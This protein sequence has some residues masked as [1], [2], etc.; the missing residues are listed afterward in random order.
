MSFDF[1]EAARASTDSNDIFT[2]L[3]ITNRDAVRASLIAVA[4]NTQCRDNGTDSGRE[5]GY[6]REDEENA[7]RVLRELI[8]VN[9]T[10]PSASRGL[11][12][13]VFGSNPNQNRVR[14]FQGL[15]TQVAMARG[16]NRGH[17]E[18][19]GP[20]VFWGN[21]DGPGASYFGNGEVVAATPVPPVNRA[22]PVFSTSAPVMTPQPLGQSGREGGLFQT[23]RG[24]VVSEGI[25][26]VAPV[27]AQTFR[28]A[29]ETLKGNGSITEAQFNQL[30]TLEGPIRDARTPSARFTLGASLASLAGV[31]D[32]GDIAGLGHVLE[33]IDRLEQ[34]DIDRLRTIGARI[35]IGSLP[36]MIQRARAVSEQFGE[37]LR[38]HAGLSQA[39]I[40]A[41]IGVFNRLSAVPDQDARAAWLG[42][43]A[44]ALGFAEES[45]IRLLSRLALNPREITYSEW[46]AVGSLLR[47][48]IGGG[49]NM[50][51]AYTR[52]QMRQTVVT[53]QYGGAIGSGDTCASYAG[54]WRSTSRNAQANPVNTRLTAPAA[55]SSLVH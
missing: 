8:R 55:A 2:I 24:W 52:E 21:Y 1:R 14:L 29:L 22:P 53:Q 11:M 50:A 42:R 7:R 15:M 47:S 37:G 54:E 34:S 41:L 16:Q 12:R 32:A 20:D 44:Q 45:Q 19:R 3:G 5:E 33:N 25:G 17:Q 51:R 28:Q 6:S 35:A 30:I 13:A 40:G 9:T 48:H 23:A 18:T 10:N 49:N 39:Q 43:F 27:A 36:T 4:R 31:R 38:T 26:V 46:R